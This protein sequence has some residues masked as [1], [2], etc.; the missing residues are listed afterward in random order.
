MSLH[1]MGLVAVGH[2]L[3]D[4]IGQ[5][6]GDAASLIEPFPSHTHVDPATMAEIVRSLSRDKKSLSRWRSGGGSANAVKAWA[7]LGLPANLVGCVGRDDGAALLRQELSGTLPNQESGQAGIEPI[8]FE[9]DKPT[10]RFCRFDTPGGKKIVASPAAARDIRRFD[11]PEKLFVEGSILH[12]DGL[13]IDNP[14]WL[15][16]IASRAIAAGMIVSLDVSTP[17]N[18]MRRGAEI[19]EFALRRCDFVFANEA[20]W[21]ALCRAAPGEFFAGSDTVWVVKRGADGASA[22]EKGRWIEEP[23]A[24]ICRPEDDIGA[25]DAFAAGFLAARMEGEA[26]AGCLA[27]GNENAALL[28]SGRMRP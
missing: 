17:F 3:L 8:L 15:D 9:S 10:G 21:G 28:L 25:G 4:Y 14:A 18:A 11:I 5:A 23:A 20:E 1:G 27:R 7:R 26:A 13:L 22:L 16:N 12:I 19:V 6:Y 24:R 2:V